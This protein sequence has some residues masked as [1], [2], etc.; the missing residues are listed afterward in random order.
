MAAWGSASL[1]LLFSVFCW[2]VHCFPTKKGWRQDNPYG[3]SFSNVETRPGR[4][5]SLSQVAPAQPTNMNDPAVSYFYDPMEGGEYYSSYPASTRPATD[6]PGQAPVLD[7]LEESTT[8]LSVSRTSQPILDIIRPPPPPP[9]QAGELEQYEENFEDG[10]FERETEDLNV[11]PPPLPV[12]PKSE[13]Q[14]GELSHYES[15]YENGNEERETEDRVYLPPP[16]YALSSISAAASTSEE[17][18]QP[19]PVPEV[20]PLGP[21]QLYLFLTGRLPP[22]THSHFQSEYE[23]GRN[24]WNDVHYERYQFPTAQS[25]TSGPQ[26]REDPSEDLW[27]EY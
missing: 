26:T 2:N 19:V 11:P 1:L 15:I 14:A 27:Q 24:H 8:G 20:E 25:P 9:F 4:H 16:P 6:P 18:L 10:N 13:Y 7:P 23:S 5:S 21:S 22:G 12:Y 17:Y 3:G